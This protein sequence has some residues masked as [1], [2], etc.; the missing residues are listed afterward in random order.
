M[1]GVKGGKPGGKRE[2]YP[3]GGGEIWSD[4]SG[5]GRT[6]LLSGAMLSE[7]VTN[8]ARMERL[9]HKAQSNYTVSHTDTRPVEPILSIFQSDRDTLFLHAQ[10]WTVL[11]LPLCTCL[12]FGM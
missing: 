3:P 8:I 2:G 9:L 1:G 5:R 11:Q 12:S 6:P 10:Y 7:C 4:I